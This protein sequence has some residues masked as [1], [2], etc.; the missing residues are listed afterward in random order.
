MWSLGERVCGTHKNL[1]LVV[2]TWILVWI[3]LYVSLADSGS[4]LEIKTVCGTQLMIGLKLKQK[5]EEHTGGKNER[6]DEKY[7]MARAGARAMYCLRRKGVSDC[8][9]CSPTARVWA[10]SYQNVRR[11][12]PIGSLLSAVCLNVKAI[13][14]IGRVKETSQRHLKE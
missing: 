13:R 5:S 9:R 11:T 10:V 1:C 12:F 4:K 6:G 8:L 7:R 2:C 3:C 14:E